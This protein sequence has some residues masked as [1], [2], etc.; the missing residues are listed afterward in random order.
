MI[1]EKDKI[2]RLIEH[3]DNITQIQL[4]ND[5]EWILESYNEYFIKSKDYDY[6]DKEYKKI[7]KKYYNLTDEKQVINEQLSLMKRKYKVLKDSCRNLKNM[8]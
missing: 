6:Q 7:L 5:L 4:K 8:I 3:K 1:Y 2:R